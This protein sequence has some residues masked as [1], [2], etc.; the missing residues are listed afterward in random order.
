MVSDIMP[1]QYE[2]S[3]ILLNYIDPIMKVQ[4]SEAIHDRCKN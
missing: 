4:T 2:N 3:S 1:I